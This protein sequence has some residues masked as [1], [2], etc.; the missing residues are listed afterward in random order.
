MERWGNSQ[1]L[2]EA[3]CHPAAASEIHP[4]P[5]LMSYGTAEQSCATKV[6]QR[7][8]N[9]HLLSSIY[10]K[11]T[12]MGEIIEYVNGSEA[13]VSSFIILNRKIYLFVQIVSLSKIFNLETV[14]VI[15]TKLNNE[16]IIS[17]KTDLTTCKAAHW[18][19]KNFDINL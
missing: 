5:S 11:T 1:P 8:N 2:V 4:N 18:R 15:C 7:L 13:T 9:L 16:M 12:T 3:G 17:D 6:H 14:Y 10:I 19:D